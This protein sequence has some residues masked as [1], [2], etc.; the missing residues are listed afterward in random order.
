M[1]RAYTKRV[2]EAQLEACRANGKKGGRPKG[3]IS[4]AEISVRKVLAKTLQEA[5][6]AN[7]LK[8]V[9]VL[10]EIAA[11]VKQPASARIGAISLLFD[12]GRGKAM[13]PEHISGNV[14][15]TVITGVPDPDEDADT[16][17]E[18]HTCQSLGRSSSMGA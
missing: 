12:R 16:P 15:L 10:E 13:Q 5:C 4:P 11:D 14:S 8:H 17:L 1:V 2:T 18:H 6:Q 3:K 7:E 9:A